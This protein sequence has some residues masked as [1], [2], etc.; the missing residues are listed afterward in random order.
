MVGPDTAASLSRGM[1]H[2]RGGDRRAQQTPPGAPVWE[3][4]ACGGVIF[5][6]RGHTVGT[7]RR[8]AVVWDQRR[9]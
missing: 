9:V 7:H 4:G 2:A 3:A 1:V 8:R 5:G 6:E